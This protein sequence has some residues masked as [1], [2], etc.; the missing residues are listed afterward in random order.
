MKVV[1]ILALMVA[2]CGCS[3]SDTVKP[4]AHVETFEER[5]QR[6]QGVTCEAITVHIEGDTPDCHKIVEAWERAQARVTA[7]GQYAPLPMSCC[8]YVRP[9]LYWFVEKA[10]PLININVDAPG[11]EPILV[12]GVTSP[13]YPPLLQYS[14]EEG[15]E[16]EA[17]HAMGM[18]QDHDRARSAEAIAA[19]EAALDRT[20]VFIWEITCHGTVDDPFLAVVPCAL[21]YSGVKNPLQ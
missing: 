20:A 12:R 5:L 21:E 16:H 13:T 15:I 1:I 17:I 8:F 3:S 7:M 18:L 10:Y 4:P 2:G 14:Y 11:Y 19:S 6:T 9:K